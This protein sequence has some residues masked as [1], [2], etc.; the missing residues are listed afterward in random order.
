MKRITAK[1]GIQS[2][3]YQEDWKSRLRWETVLFFTNFW[4]GTPA[5]R[6]VTVGNCVHNRQGGGIIYIYIETALKVSVITT[7]KRTI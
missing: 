2:D 7:N 3:K 1:M 4:S 6:Q 5:R